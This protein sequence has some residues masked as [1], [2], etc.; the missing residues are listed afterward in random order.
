MRRTRACSRVR[1]LC[2]AGLLPLGALASCSSAPESSR[3]P[4]AD[5]RGGLVSAAANG[6]SFTERHRGIEV[7]S[8]LAPNDEA[9]IASALA[10]FESEPV[11][12]EPWAIERW[13]RSGIRVLSIPVGRLD[14]LRAGLD[15]AGSLQSRWLGEASEWI[16]VVEG[17]DLPAGLIATEDGPVSLEGGRLRLIV[18][19]WVT[20]MTSPVGD[21]F[22][23]GV[24]VEIVPQ[25]TNRVD[26]LREAGF[27][28]RLTPKPRDPL[29]EGLVFRRLGLAGVLPGD[30]ALLF[31]A[32]L[33]ETDWAAVAR[34]AE[35]SDVPGDDASA[36]AGS[37]ASGAGPV[38]AVDGEEPASGGVGPVWTPS[39]WSGLDVDAG[40]EPIGPLPPRPRWLGEAMLMSDP[41]HGG[42]R[43][44][45]LGSR[46]IVV[47]TPRVPER[48]ELLGSVAR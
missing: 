5:D 3:A 17:P 37:E 31:V 9:A 8:W 39:P 43:Y 22:G 16:P 35:A 21:G 14:D 47:L 32:E 20:P 40:G 13:R 1:L 11:P 36:S 15:Q 10:G 23:A 30:R 4:D 46:L 12:V 48:F 34:E 27:D 2:A 45:T 38:S 7:Q 19:S 18:R 28:A 26:P 33:P 29:D 25:H 44:R 42:G 41:G 24:Y 6:P